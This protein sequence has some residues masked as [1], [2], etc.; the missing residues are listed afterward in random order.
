MA[1][2]QQPSGFNPRKMPGQTHSNSVK[3][4]GPVLLKVPGEVMFNELPF[5][6][7]PHIVKLLPEPH[8]I[9][10]DFEGVFRKIAEGIEGGQKFAHDLQTTNMPEVQQENALCTALTLPSLYG[11]KN[12]WP[13]RDSNPHAFWAVD[14]ESTAS[15]IPPLGLSTNHTQQTPQGNPGSR[16]SGSRT[17]GG[18]PSQPWHDS[19]HCNPSP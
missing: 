10:R 18:L 5:T 15:A 2:V 19:I 1:A 4:L 3:F 16:R 6:T 17:F 8:S 7:N 14:F 9:F 13:R 11:Q 12:H